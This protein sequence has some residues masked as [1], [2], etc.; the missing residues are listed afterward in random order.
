MAFGSHPHHSPA[1]SAFE[2]TDDR[3]PA[4][5]CRATQQSFLR[6]LSTPI[7]QSTYGVP[8]IS[9]AQ[10]WEK[11]EELAG[12]PQVLFAEEEEGLTA[13]WR[14]FAARDTVSPKV[15]MDAYLAAFAIVG[16]LEFVTLDPDFQAYEAQ[17]LQLRLL[18]PPS[19]Q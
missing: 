6:Q 19:T 1:K 7:L 13:L 3:N 9:N 8:A 17:G 10:A 11:W 15:W 5:F 12:L 18:A 14:Q 2:M 16:R 4:V